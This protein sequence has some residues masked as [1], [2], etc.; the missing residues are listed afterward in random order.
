MSKT[1]KFTYKGV[2]YTLEYSR[3]T[4]SQMESKGFR[5]NEMDSMPQT[6]VSMLFAG[7]FLMHHRKV[8]INTSLVEEIFGKFTNRDELIT[9]L[10]KMYQEPVLSL[11]DEPEEDEGNIKWGTD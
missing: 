2:N 5:L 10:V 11:F 1:I 3:E 8:A 7:A 4:V 6:M 9:T